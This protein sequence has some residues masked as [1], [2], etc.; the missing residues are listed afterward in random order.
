VRRF[1]LL[2]YAD[3]NKAAS[4]YRVLASCLDG[5]EIDKGYRLQ[6]IEDP[7]RGDK[8]WPLYSGSSRVWM[9][10]TPVAIDRLYKVPTRSPDGQQLSSN[11]RHLRRLAEWTMLIRASLR[12][13]RLPDDLAA[14]CKITLTSSPLLPGSERAERY[15]AKDER[16]PFVHARI[17]FTRHVRGPLLVGDR[18][19]QGFGL[20]FPAK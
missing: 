5:E 1:A 16:A 2:G 6:L 3:S 19:Y 15:R 9:S 12:H 20:F 17:E 18:R 11:E 10:A 8:V 7:L 14:T 4:I 13:I